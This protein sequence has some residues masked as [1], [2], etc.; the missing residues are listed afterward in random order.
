MIDYTK[1]NT[2]DAIPEAAS[3]I[4]TF[5]AI[6]YSLETAVADIIDNSISAGAKN[7][8]INRIWKGEESLL[9]IKDDG[10]GMNG[11]ELIQ[12]LKPG[13]QNPLAARHKN[14]LGRFGL[15]LKTASFSQCRRL[16]VITRKAEYVPVF[17][18]WDLDYVAQCKQWKLIQWL[19]EQYKEEFPDG[20]V[21]TMV[22]WSA[23]DRIIPIGTKEDNE[24]AK[25]KFSM[26]FDRVKNHLAMT[27][28]RFIEDKSIRIY[29]G[30]HE[31]EPWNPFCINE[32][33]T[34]IFPEE[35]ICDSHGAFVRGYV[36]PH[37]K[38]FTSEQVYRTSEG[39]KGWGE[40]QGF[41][42]YRG[43][44]L[45]L[46]GD[47]LGLFRKEEHY[48]LARIRIDLPNTQ[49]DLWQIDIKK[50]SARPPMAYIQQLKAYASNIRSNA[51]KVYRHRGRVLRQRAGQSFSPLWLDKNVDGKWSFVI[52]RENDV[53]VSL[54]EL[55]KT[56]PE[57]AINLILRFV[58]ESLPVP[59][60]HIKD[61]S[62][63]SENKEPFS[64][65]SSATIKTVLRC[66]YENHLANGL[67]SQQAKEMLKYQE[68][69]NLYEDLIEEL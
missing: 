18:T 20:S 29:W 55:A 56:K 31:I 43:K 4:E 52:N 30:E 68:P 65:V 49:D 14:D 11:E 66:A 21:G 36:L 42:I 54:T 3:M 64:D 53:I 51:E 22:I 63:E 58:E 15:G 26:L 35:E 9:T 67:T 28:H 47:W 34:Q 12:A 50:S 19:P 59:S 57:Q 1:I 6:G 45:L 37:R 61:A 41:Y 2:A 17:W 48:K 24:A 39:I 23:L 25:A 16:S 38:N 46:A 7:I 44:R 60:I 13:A 5:R 62:R 33:K 32:P 10:C 27:F 69:F 8:W 40:Q